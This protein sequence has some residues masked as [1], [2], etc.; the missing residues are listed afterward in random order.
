MVSYSMRIPISAQR[1]LAETAEDCRRTNNV[2]SLLGF[3]RI[4]SSS[5]V[6]RMGRS[7]MRGDIASSAPILTQLDDSRGIVY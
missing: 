5:R 2:V 3:L 4:I 7:F 1:S 6:Q